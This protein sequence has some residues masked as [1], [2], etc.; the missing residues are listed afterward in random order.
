MLVRL[1]R[2]G[3]P[4]SGIVRLESLTYGTRAAVSSH[5]AP[6]DELPHAE[7]EVYSGLL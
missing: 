3:K 1:R 2:A 5:H 7:R 6:R 4:E